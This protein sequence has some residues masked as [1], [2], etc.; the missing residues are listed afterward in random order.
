MFPHDQPY[1]F[2]NTAMQLEYCADILETTERGNLSWDSP[3]EEQASHRI[4]KWCERYIIAYD[5]H[6]GA[7]PED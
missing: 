1:L 4:H 3:E 2:Q 7:K 5:E 6:Q